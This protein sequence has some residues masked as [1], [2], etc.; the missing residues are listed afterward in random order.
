MEQH[1][2]LKKHSINSNKIM[3]FKI[4]VI[5]ISVYKEEL[6][7]KIICNIKSMKLK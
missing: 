3:K 1:Q 5:K 7:T 6:K 2:F 4:K